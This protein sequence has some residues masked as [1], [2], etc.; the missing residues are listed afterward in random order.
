MEHLSLLTLNKTIKETLDAHLEPSYWVVAEISELRV[1]QKGHCYM[2]WVEKDAETEQLLAKMRANVWS[3]NYRKISGWFESITGEDLRPGLKIL[4][5]VVVQF[6]ELYGISL[7]VRD[8]DPNFTLGE[9]ARKRQEIINRL[10]E[11]GVFEMNR[12]LPMPEVPK[13]LA[14]ISSATAAG[15]GDFMDQLS[16][17]P[18]GFA[19]NVD[20]YPALMQGDQ[21]P[22]NIIEQLH[23]IAQQGDYDWVVIIRGGGAQV[24]LDCFDHYELASHVAQFPIPV[25]TGIG[26]E[27]DETIVDLVAH[28]KMK[29]PTAVAA[30][31]LQG[32]L[33]QEDRLLVLWDRLESEAQDQLQLADRK[34]DRLSDHLKHL[35]RGIMQQQWNQLDRLKHDMRL[36]A[37]GAFQQAEMQLKH[38]DTI[39]KARDPQKIMEMG[40]TISTV[41][42]QPLH[43][44][45]EW[46]EGA[47]LKTQHAKGTVY[48]T[49]KKKK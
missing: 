35:S 42:G 7:V 1:N 9:R 29:T 44:K 37:K 5:N 25:I 23:A 30:F 38:L 22:A 34:L 33:D 26:H 12:Q 11:D 20:F 49:I 16:T 2:E 41:E 45:K 31:L 36:L 10:V 24:D 8:I 4:A 17:N 28:T 43:A 15:Y 13:R 3:Y 32:M 19:F 18:Q 48:S 40:F 27:R 47:E 14:V 6:H 46:S 39:L 21:A